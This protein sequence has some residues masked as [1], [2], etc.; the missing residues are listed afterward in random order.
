LITRLA[1]AVQVVESVGSALLKLRG[2]GVTGQESD[3][4]QLK[5]PIDL[6]AEGWV[7]G[8]LQGLFPNDLFLAEEACERS[9]STSNPHE[10][11]WTVDALDGSRS[12]VEGF[13]GFCAQVAYVDQG[14]VTV[15]AVHEPVAGTTYWAAAGQGAFIRE[16][17]GTVKQL[18][19]MKEN[20]W[21]EHP[22]FVDSTPPKG[23]IGAMKQRLNGDLVVCGSIG[24]KICRIA[25][26]MADVFAKE[27]SFAVWDVAPGGLILEEAGGRVGLW[28]GEQVSLHSPQIYYN[29]ILA[30]PSGLFELAVRELQ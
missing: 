9:R 20:A 13:P 16:S 8:F 7:T 19:L 18:N 10:S 5:T 30:A 2:A 23:S 22:R 6:A 17:N 28:N 12:F 26:G 14:R 21:P 15:A 24:V 3:R 1:A 29:N 4:Q 11:F 25:Q 27:L